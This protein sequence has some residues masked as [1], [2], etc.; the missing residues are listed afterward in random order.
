MNL[1]LDLFLTLAKVGMFTFGGGY[2]MISIIE[3]TCV[4]KKKWITHEEM[5]DITVIAESTPGPIAINAA[6]YVGYKQAG[7][8]GSVVATVGIVLPSFVIIYLISSVLDDFLEIAWIANAFRGIKIGVGLLIFRVALNMLKKMKP[9]PMPRIIAGCAFAVMLT[10]N[11][12]SLKFSSIT[13]M[14]IAGTVSLAIF[15]AKDR[16]GGGK[17]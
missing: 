15:L 14:L 5:M 6:T 3:D 1:L 2:A 13:L 4:E 17:K 16:K 10:V 9:K 7:I 12:L 11:F 8:P